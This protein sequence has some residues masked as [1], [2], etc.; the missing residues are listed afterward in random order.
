MNMSTNIPGQLIPPSPPFI[1]G[2]DSDCDDCNRRVLNVH[3][4]V[5][6]VDQLTEN[7]YE[8]MDNPSIE[9]DSYQ[10]ISGVATRRQ[11]L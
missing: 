2:N 8:T 7:K 5:E 4:A 3:C 9:A 10:D 1:F 11:D 6:D